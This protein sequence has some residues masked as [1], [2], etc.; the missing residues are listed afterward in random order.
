MRSQAVGSRNALLYLET[1]SL[2]RPRTHSCVQLGRRPMWPAI[3][4]S[5]KLPVTNAAQVTSLIFSNL[6]DDGASVLPQRIR[7]SAVR[8]DAG[9]VSYTT[10]ASAWPPAATATPSNLHSSGSPLTNPCYGTMCWREVNHQA[11]DELGHCVRVGAF[12]G[13]RSQPVPQ[14]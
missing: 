7:D 13:E 5:H 2:P 11:T 1:A 12:G 4:F 10:L 9:A 6:I 14:A 8:N 3:T